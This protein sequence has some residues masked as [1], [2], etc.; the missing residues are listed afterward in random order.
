VRHPPTD[1]I[2]LVLAQTEI[3][4]PPLV[5]EIPLHLVTARCPWWRS[6]PEALAA[7]GVAEPFWGFAWAGG[8]ALARFLLDHPEVARGRR[9][10][11][12]G[13]GSGLAGLAAARAGAFRA[14]AA[15]IDPVCH[16]ACH[17]NAALNGLALG[18]TSH[19]LVGRPLRVDLVVAGDVTYDAALTARVLP[20]LRALAARGSMVLL[21]DPGRG[22]LPGAGLVELARYDAPADND[23][24]FS[25]PRETPVFALNP[26][27]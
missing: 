18:F 17:L 19:D 9:V 7:E 22:F 11:D 6:S 10:L 21:A 14:I 4:C 1:D 15:D 16:A 20:W 13:A 5:P 24:G 27:S 3:A 26:P 2:S 25:W 8:Q 23:P 12:F